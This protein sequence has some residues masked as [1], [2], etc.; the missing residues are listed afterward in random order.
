MVTKDE[1][2]IK[3]IDFGS[4]KDLQGTEFEKKFDEERAK[5]TRKKNAYKNFVGTPNYMAPECVR[6]KG[7][8]KASDIWSLGCLLYQLFTGFPPF[9]GKSDYLIFLKSTEV[10]Y[11]F[12]EDVVDPEAKDLISKMIVLEPENRL[13]MEEVYKHEFL[14][15]VDNTFPSAKL[16]EKDYLAIVNGF[17]DQ[18]SKYKEISRKL[19]KIKE[20]EAMNEEYIKNY[21]EEKNVEEHLVKIDLNEK[22]NL[23]QENEKGL[24]DLNVKLIATKEKI[25]ILFNE[26]ELDLKIYINKLT[27]LE[28][29]LKHDLFGLE[30]E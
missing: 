18:F 29:Q 6:N 7:S 15:G 27:Y 8:D 21:G 11:E 23:Q 9:L 14:K 25:N 4:C 28:K 2:T 22:A 20:A 19:K 13:L 3:I 26:K 5:Q 1:K 16:A 30:L 17:K 12:P 10:K 24:E